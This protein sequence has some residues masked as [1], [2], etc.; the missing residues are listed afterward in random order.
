MCAHDLG[1]QVFGCRVTIE[2]AAF[3]TFFVVYNELHGDI[4][5]ARPAWVWCVAAIANQIARITH[6]VF[7]QLFMVFL[8]I[9]KNYADHSPSK[10]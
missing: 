4:G 3:A 10:F 7:P 2:N 6:M 1:K 9:I 5:P 8:M